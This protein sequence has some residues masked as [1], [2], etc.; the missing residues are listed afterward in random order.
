MLDRLLICSGF[1]SA[2][3]LPIFNAGNIY[4]EN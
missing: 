3:L 2:Q 4:E 1:V